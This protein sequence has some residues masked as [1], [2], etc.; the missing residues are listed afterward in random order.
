VPLHDY[1]DSVHS[2]LASTLT[3]FPLSPGFHFRVP[4]T[5]F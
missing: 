2:H 5:I 3:R 1:P 4:L